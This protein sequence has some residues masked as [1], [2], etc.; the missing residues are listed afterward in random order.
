M[1][2]KEREI[3]RKIAVK[4]EWTWFVQAILEDTHLVSVSK[5]EVS[6]VTIFYDSFLEDDV[7][8]VLRSVE[9]FTIS[10]NR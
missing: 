4:K 5:G 3:V 8:L 2:I 9:E 10:C 1:D 6:N 7:N